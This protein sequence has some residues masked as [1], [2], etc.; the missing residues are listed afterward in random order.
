MPRAHCERAG[1]LLGG[2]FG[3]ASSSAY[4]IERAVQG[5]GHDKAF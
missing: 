5:T 1:D 4:E 3:R 2:V